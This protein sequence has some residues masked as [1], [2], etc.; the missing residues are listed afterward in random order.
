MNSTF[1]QHLTFY[2]RYVDDICIIWNGGETELTNFLNFVNSLHPNITF[3]LEKETNQ[4]LPFLDLLLIREGDKISFE[5]YRKPSTTDNIIQYNSNSPH[6]HKFAAFHSFF[7][8]LFK[9]PLSRDAF[10]KELQIIKMLAT[11]NGFPLQT[12]NKLFYKY[13]NKH[14]LLTILSIKLTTEAI[15]STALLSLAIFLCWWPMFLRGMAFLSALK[16]ITPY[17]HI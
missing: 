10:Q 6:T 14:S 11:N 17:T 4:K 3:T 8:R 7:Y 12:I 5:I 16:P 2:R 1:A 9:I 13:F 15:Y